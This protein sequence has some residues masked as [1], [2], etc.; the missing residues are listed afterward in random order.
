MSN[1]TNDP[2]APYGEEREPMLSD[3]KI[4]EMFRIS[5]EPPEA[6]EY[7]GIPSRERVRTFYEN[8]ISS[9]ELIRRDELL[10][11]L[12][13]KAHELDELGNRADTT[14]MAAPYDYKYEAINEVIDHLN[15][16]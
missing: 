10:V 12:Q 4:E 3:D 5:G 7:V 1:T 15:K 2:K 16:K 9:G 14:N 11:W 13:A 6:D 8:L